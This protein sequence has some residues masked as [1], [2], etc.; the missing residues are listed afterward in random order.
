MKRNLL[1][2]TVLALFALVPGGAISA[3]AEMQIQMIDHDIQRLTTEK[4]EKIARLASCAKNTNGFKIA[5][6]STLALTGVGIGV[7]ISQYNIKSGLN[8]QIDAERTRIQE[9]Q[10]RIRA[11]RDAADNNNRPPVQGEAG[12]QN[13]NIMVAQKEQVE[14]LD[15]MTEMAAEVEN[16]DEQVAQQEQIAA[17]VR[18]PSERAKEEKKLADAKEKKEEAERKLKVAQNNYDQKNGQIEK[19]KSTATGTRES[20]TLTRN[21]A[22][23][24]STAANGSQQN[25]IRSQEEINEKA[26]D[27]ADHAKALDGTLAVTTIPDVQVDLSPMNRSDNMTDKERE[28]ELKALYKKQASA[29]ATAGKIG[30]D[31]WKTEADNAKSAK[32]EIRNTIEGAERRQM[33][34]LLKREHPDLM[35]AQTL[36]DQER[37]ELAL[38]RWNAQQDWATYGAAL[39]AKISELTAGK[40]REKENQQL[41]MAKND[42]DRRLAAVDIQANNLLNFSLSENPTMDEINRGLG[43]VRNLENEVSSLNAEVERWKNTFGAAYVSNSDRMYMSGLAGRAINHG[44]IASEKRQWL[45]GEKKKIQQRESDERARRVQDTRREKLGQ[46]LGGD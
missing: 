7:N 18:N 32:R 26:K 8:K 16:L 3:T 12:D 20:E 10:D 39:D 33:D 42:M 30:G 40:K 41:A 37:Y 25:R 45:E 14:A 29:T 34:D 36:T 13:V 4:N 17:A 22:P 5:G 44:S 21:T 6:I 43:I 27:L 28:R 2:S 15:Q 35:A 24:E 9:E 23:T 11:V 1:F 38:L 31:Y 46:I 19:A